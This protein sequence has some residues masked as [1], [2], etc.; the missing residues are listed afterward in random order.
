MAAVRQIAIF[1]AT[2]LLAG[3]LGGALVLL[4]PGFGVDE[5]EL[6]SRLAEDSI[7]TLRQGHGEERNI[8]RFYVGHLAGMMKGDLGVS[9]AL[10][11][12]IAQLFRERGPLTLQLIGI[13]LAGGW[14][15]GLGL[16]VPMSV[17]RIPAYDCISG[18]FSGLFL[19]L[20]S[21]V[22]ALLLFLFGG[23]IRSAIAFAIFPKVFRYTRNLLL[24]SNALP[25][26]LMAKAKGLGKTRILF[27]HVLP[28]AAPQLVALAG[29]SVSMAIGAA[30]PVEVICD[31]PGIGQ[32][33]WKAA[34]ARDLPLLISLTV[35]IATVTLLANSASDLAVAACG[36]NRQ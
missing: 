5:R 36:R 3:F 25:H 7:R 9:R 32:L 15:L 31:L 29:V 24:E 30:I 2:I 11:R 23:P 22:L 27:L 33:A 17:W 8:L 10:D 18:I 28:W 1:L 4:A 12:P 35:V 13:G 26:V 20:P 14:L 16:A 6:D 34:L 19:C 21:A